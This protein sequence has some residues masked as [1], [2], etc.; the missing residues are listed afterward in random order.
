MRKVKIETDP[1]AIAELMLKGPG[2]VEWITAACERVAARCRA[3]AGDDA[4]FAVSIRVGK[5]R[6]RGSVITVNGPAIEAESKNR[7]LTRAIDAAR[8]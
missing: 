4:V 2:A 7:V 5:N 3:Q 8:G 6:V 1:D